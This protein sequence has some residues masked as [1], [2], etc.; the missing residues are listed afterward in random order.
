MARTES[1]RDVFRRLAAQRTTAV[2]DRL[3]VLGHC[4]DSQRYEYTEEDVRRIFR[5]IESE[6]K[7]V[8][9]KFTNSTKSEFQL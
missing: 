1:K 7:V 8:K 3:R 9:A 5:A 6:L 4:S 2:L